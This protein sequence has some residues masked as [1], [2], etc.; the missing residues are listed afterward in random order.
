MK[1]KNS[2]CAIFIAFAMSF[3]VPVVAAAGPGDEAPKQEMARQIEARI[4]EIHKM[5]KSEM[6]RAEKKE[7]KKEVKN[8]RKK[9]K[10]QGV[11]LSIGAIIIII[12]LLI[13]LL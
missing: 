7:L 5:D 4:Y 11:Y 2:I 6:S 13:L 10:T 1:R 12:L 9:A 3:A 8:L